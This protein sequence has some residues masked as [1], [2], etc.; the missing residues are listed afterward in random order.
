MHGLIQHQAFCTSV[1][2]FKPAMHW[3]HQE[4]WQGH[5]PEGC[6]NVCFSFPFHWLRKELIFDPQDRWSLFEAMKFKRRTILARSAIRYIR[7][8][9][10]HAC[11]LYIWS[12]WARMYCHLRPLPVFQCC[13]CNIE[14]VT[15]KKWEWHG[16]EASPNACMFIRLCWVYKFMTDV[17][18]IQLNYM[19]VVRVQLSRLCGTHSGS[20]QLSNFHA[21]LDF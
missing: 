9:C 18:Y 16:D 19:Y 17:P 12:E 6:C 4:A 11:T 10:V 15:L 21:Y 2:S 5:G 20:P 8:V 14:K 1:L 7:T 13:T 3:G